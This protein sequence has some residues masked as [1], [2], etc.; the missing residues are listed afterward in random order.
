ME[1]V[2]GASLLW[3]LCSSSLWPYCSSSG[4][5]DISVGYLRL[6]CG[7]PCE[8]GY[9]TVRTYGVVCLE[10][11]KEKNT[12]GFFFSERL[13]VTCDCCLVSLVVVDCGSLSPLSTQAK[14]AKGSLQPKIA[15]AF[16]GGCELWMSVVVIGYCRL[17][18]C[19][20]GLW[21]SIRSGTRKIC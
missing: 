13:L 10:E 1:L 4:K 17:C 5:V 11:K 19:D 7:A 16:A 12:R 6:D 9:S 20:C 3:M 2:C 14:Q 21:I 15:R 18:D 8:S